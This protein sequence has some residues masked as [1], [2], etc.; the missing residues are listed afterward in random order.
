MWRKSAAGWPPPTLNKSLHTINRLTIKRSMCREIPLVHQV[1]NNDG[2]H[3]REREYPCLSIVHCEE[4]LGDESS[5]GRGEATRQ[6]LLFDFQTENMI[7]LQV[8][9]LR[10]NPRA[11]MHGF[12]K[13]SVWLTFKA[14][15]NIQFYVDVLLLQRN[16]R[17]QDRR[18]ESKPC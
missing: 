6:F 7:L 9:T 11:G 17:D 5:T 15:W 4:V 1:D 3:W 10:S 13:K 12:R 8:S 2:F 16:A 14:F 18:M